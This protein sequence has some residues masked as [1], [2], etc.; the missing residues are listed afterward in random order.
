MKIIL[1]LL[2]SENGIDQYKKTIYQFREPLEP[3]CNV[4]V[5]ESYESRVLQNLEEK[6]SEK[7]MIFDFPDLIRTRRPNSNQSYNGGQQVTLT[8][9]M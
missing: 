8:S 3:W 6:V 2:H 1:K 5:N 7:G 9:Y 4:T